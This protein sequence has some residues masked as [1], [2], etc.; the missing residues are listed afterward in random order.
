MEN[1]SKYLVVIAGPTAIGKTNLSIQL[2]RY[3]NTEIISADSRQFYKQMTIGT[4][5][6]TKQEQALIKHHLIDFLEIEQ[7]LPAGKYEALVLSLLNELYKTK[8][9]V[10][11]TGGSGLFIDAVLNGVDTLPEKDEE[12]RNKLNQLYQ[13]NGIVALQQLLLEKDFEYYHRIDL[14]N[15][16][17][18]IRALEVCLLTGKPYSAQ[19]T[20]ENK[21]RSFIPVKIALNTDRELLYTR[22]NQRVDTM[23]QQ[24]LLEEVKQLINYSHCNALNPVGYK[25]LFSYLNGASTLNEAVELIKKNTRNYAK[26]QLTWF[27]KD[28]EYAWFEPNDEKNIIKVIEEK[29]N[30]LSIFNA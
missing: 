5:K 18:L 4:A 15:P 9:L 10:I 12:L 30:S 24:G 28:K 11:L 25:E 23:M 16:H 7:N 17:R 6:P 29:I 8:S 13:Q 1:I 26:R 2:A 3:F 22:I 14:N 20:K 27:R 19:L 21:K